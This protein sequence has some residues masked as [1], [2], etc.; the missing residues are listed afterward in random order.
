M[1]ST[2]RRQRQLARERYARQQTR[3]AASAHKRRVR[4]IIAGLVLVS[5]VVLVAGGLL[6]GQAI[7]AGNGP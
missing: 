3:R 7:S 2:K 1:A 5:V 4:Q 6:V